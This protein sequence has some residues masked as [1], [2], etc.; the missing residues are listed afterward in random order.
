[1][2]SVLQYLHGIEVIES[3]SGIRPI[4]LV[5]SSIIGIVGTA[6]NADPLLFPLNEPVILIG[7]QRKAA[8]LGQAGTLLN[9]L[10]DI[11][12]LGIAPTVVIT[13][14][15]QAST[16]AATMSNV[17]GSP[18]LKTGVWSFLRAHSQV[19]VKPRIIIA[20]GFTSHRPVD[21]VQR[22]AMS[23]GGNYVNAPAVMISGDGFGAQ[24]TAVL[25]NGA[26]EAVVITNPG[27]GYSG[28]TVSF[29]VSDAGGDQ[30]AGAA[31]MG[32]TAN[33]VGKAL[34]AVATR[35]RAVTFLDGPNISNEA[36][37][38]YRS[39]Y[40]SDRVMVLDPHPLVWSRTLNAYVPRPP[41]SLAAGMQ[42]LIDNTRGFWHSFSN[43]PLPAVGGLSRPI[44]WDL[45]NPDTE[46]NYLNAHEVTPIVRVDSADQGGYRFWG[47]RSCSSDPQ[48][49]FLSVRRT[50]DM[51]YE[52]VIQGFLWMMDKPFS[53]QRVTD[54]VRTVDYYM[55][56]LQRRGATLGGKAWIDPGLNTQDQLMSGHLSISFDFE[57]PAPI[58][59]LSFHANRESAYYDV[60][61]EE[62][63][64]DLAV[65]SSTVSGLAQQLS[66]GL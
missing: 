12:S 2:A 60:L 29:G 11:Y 33:P 36:A 8:L 32:V 59:R 56:T 26:V 1:M 28:A 40:G 3:D 43:N 46:S 25:S 35:L 38:A 16:A 55:R 53:R 47:L 17:I 14:V 44:A 27:H 9:A 30:A 65:R 61:M 20:P 52:S 5:K 19:H 22:I 21:G 7:D 37:A 13:R 24:G 6:P 45:E 57:P 4:R 10:L 58:E 63:L 62:V 23:A 50:A 18:I 49:A 34:E 42:C 54:G 48:W 15:A 39:D 31:V 51:I 41:S 66:S 64:R